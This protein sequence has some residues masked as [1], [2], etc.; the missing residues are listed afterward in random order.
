MPVRRIL[1]VTVGPV[2]SFYREGVDEYRRRLV[3][4]CSVQL[5]SVKPEPL[6]ARLT[7][8]EVQM[9]REREGERLLAAA[10]GH[11]LLLALDRSGRSFSSEAF[12]HA[13]EQWWAAAGAR[14]VFVVGGTLGLSQAVQ[15]EAAQLLSLS[16]LTFP[17][18]LAALVLLEQ[19]YRAFRILRGEPYHY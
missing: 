14:L 4:Y 8:A 17:H 11:G 6:P 7:E 5:A 19:L 3:P 1:V 15:Q 18:E 16:S 12:A 10:T 9:V 13:L 2:R